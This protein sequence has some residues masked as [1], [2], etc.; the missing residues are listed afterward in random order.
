MLGNVCELS[1]DRKPEDPLSLFTLSE[2][3]A[4]IPESK[5]KQLEDFY[6]TN[7]DDYF[8]NEQLPIFVDDSNYSEQGET[9]LNDLINRIPWSKR[10]ES[11]IYPRN[12][13]ATDPIDKKFIVSLKNGL[14]E[15]I[16]PHIPK[17]MFAIDIM[18]DN[19][20]KDIEKT[21]IK[22]LRKISAVVMILIRYLKWR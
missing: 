17:Y 19:A 3:D 18:T 10:Y 11:K 9:I 1:R 13:K 21:E 8:L 20:F 4:A 5:L 14:F 7:S 6:I 16:S 12:L 2:P 15:L 22:L